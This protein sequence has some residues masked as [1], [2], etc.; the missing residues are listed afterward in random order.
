MVSR[1]TFM[2]GVPAA[3]LGSR[4]VLG[5]PLAGAVDFLADSFVPSQNSTR[6]GNFYYLAPNGIAFIKEDAAAFVINPGGAHTAGTVAP[7]DSFHKVIFT[8][9]TAKPNGR[10]VEFQ[11][12]RR[13]DAIVGRLVS[14]G[15]GEMSFSLSENWPGFSSHFSADT[16]GVKGLAALAGGQTVTWSLK[17]SPVVKSADAQQFTVALGGPGKPTYLVAGFG[18]LPSFDG[19][20]ALLADAEKAYEARRPRAWGAS[21]DILAAIADNMNN[22]R[23][24][25]SDNKM[26]AISVSRTFGTDSPNACPY[27]CWDSFFSGLLAC[28]DDPAM[29]RQTVR[30]ILSGQTEEGLVPN[31]VHW[32]NAGISKDRSQPPV[33]SMCIWKMHQHWPDIDFL[34]EVYPKLATWHAWWMK[35][36]N[37]RND[38]LLQ[39]GS[40]NSVLQDAQYETGWDDTPHFEGVEGIK[41]VGHTMNVHAVDLCSLWAMDAHYLALIADAIGKPEDAR[42]YRKDE[43]DM[44]DR[45]NAKLWNEKIG[46]YCSRFWDKDDGTPGGFLTRLTPAN[47]YPLICGAPGAAY[48]QRVLATMTDPEQFWGEWILPTVSRKDPLFLQQTYWHGTIWGPVNYLVWQGVK[49]YASPEVKAAYAQKSVHLFMNNWLA[50]GYCGENFLSIDGSVGG[51]R[52]YTWGALMCLIGVE[53][54]VDISNNGVAKIGPGYNESVELTNLPIGGKRHRASVRFGTPEVKITL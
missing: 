31:Y 14:V 8:P 35:A 39:W 11:W 47:F 41:M 16:G 36:R 7:D 3:Y 10:R 34:H 27:F 22:S 19:I 1:R 12:S 13:G 25:A 48:A 18:E 21:G 52:Y 40:S 42:H 28:L 24:Y 5:A 50:N 46:I 6:I 9:K 17:A 32:N 4:R 38:G 51:N 45:I 15:P 30:A 29:G 37:G 43:A 33:G 23:M 49:R 53:S 54:V 44:N 2:A 20:D 26:V